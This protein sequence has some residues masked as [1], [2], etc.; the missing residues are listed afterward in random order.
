MA[1]LELKIQSWFQFLGLKKSYGNN[2]VSLHHSG[3]GYLV[4]NWGFEFLGFFIKTYYKQIGLR[5]KLFV[6]IRPS[7]ESVKGVLI[8]IKNIL[9]RFNKLSVV[10]FR[11]QLIISA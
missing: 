6:S 2:P 1:S 9:R 7:L 4:K 10:I 3:K 8:G 5:R 11:I